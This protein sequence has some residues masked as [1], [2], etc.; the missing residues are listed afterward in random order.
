MSNAFKLL[1]V[2]MAFICVAARSESED[3]PLETEADEMDIEVPK[4]ED[5]EMDNVEMDDIKRQASKPCPFVCGY[6]SLVK[7]SQNTY[8]LRLDVYKC[9][10]KACGSAY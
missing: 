7:N 4:T 6:V 3:I 5:D 9:C 2:A 8:T 10:V 1:A